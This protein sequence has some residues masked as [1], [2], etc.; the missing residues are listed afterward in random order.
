MTVRQ[1]REAAI[2]K[3]AQPNSVLKLAL[4]IGPLL[5]FFFV[6]GRAGIFWAT[7]VFMMALAVSLVLSRLLLGKLPVVPLVSGVIVFVFG[8]LTLY[9]QDETFIKM[10]PTIVN[11]LFGGLLLGGLLFGK[12]LIGYVLGE[13]INL[14]DRGWKILTLSWG[15][16]FLVLAGLNEIVW[17]NTSTDT[18]VAFKVWGIMPLTIAFSLAQVPIMMRHMIEDAEPDT[19]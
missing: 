16:F 6:N 5:I 10:K 15:L 7:G 19:F 8:G 3:K 11:V 14:T 13:S 2:T 4:E 1:S 18:W 9:L 12:S 17:R